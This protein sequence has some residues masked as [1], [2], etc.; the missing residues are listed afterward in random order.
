MKKK[1]LAISMLVVGVLFS[2]TSDN[3]DQTRRLLK[4]DKIVYSIGDDIVLD[5]VITSDVEKQIYFYD[6]F[7]NLQIWSSVIDQCDSNSTGWCKKKTHFVENKQNKSEGIST[8]RLDRSSQFLKSLICK[9]EEH[10]E[11]VV[12]SIPELEY[13]AVYLKSDFTK[14]SKL[15]IHGLC[16]P[17]NPSFNSSI[18]AYFNVTEIIINVKT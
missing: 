10:G 8:Y 12:F 4:T 13:R 17:V 6:D 16:I 1:S 11:Q 9:T 3:F 7:H 5:V 2:C 15:R 18:E 14:N